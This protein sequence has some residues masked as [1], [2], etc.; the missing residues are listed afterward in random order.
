MNL[1]VMLKLQ[2]SP[3][4][5]LTSLVQVFTGNLGSINFAESLSKDTDLCNYPESLSGNGVSFYTNQ[6]SQG[7]AHIM[8]QNNASLSFLIYIFLF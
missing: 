4:L 6:F 1:S 8:L 5:G 3:P 7:T 2:A